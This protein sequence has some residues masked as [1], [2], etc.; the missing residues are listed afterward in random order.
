LSQ[1]FLPLLLH[2]LSEGFKFLYLRCVLNLSDDIKNVS[3]LK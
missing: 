1:G 3:H 2:L